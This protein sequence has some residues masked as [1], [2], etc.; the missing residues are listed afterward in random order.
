MKTRFLG[1]PVILL[2]AGPSVADAT[3]AG[4][5]AGPASGVS[6]NDAV[7]ASANVDVNLAGWQTYGGF[8]HALNSQTFI[9]VPAGSEVVGFAFLGVAATTAGASWGEE[10]VLSVNNS[11]GSEWLDWAPFGLSG[12]FPGSFGPVSGTWNGAVG[13]PPIDF[14]T[15]QPVPGAEGAP[16]F[17]LGDKLIWITAYESFNDAGDGLDATITAGTLRVYLNF[18]PPPIP[19]PEPAAPAL[20]GLGLVVL[21]LNRRRK[22]A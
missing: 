16:F 13:S 15:G 5:A 18:N 3:T 22:A 19:V 17:V 12:N 6:V 11:A 1:L 9:G 20:L 14:F 4:F 21:G 7:R 10:I 2:L 8:G